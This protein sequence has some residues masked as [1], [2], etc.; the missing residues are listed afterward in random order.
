MDK[1]GW[2]SVKTKVPE[3]ETHIL[4]YAVGCGIKF[5]YRQEFTP[6]KNG[7]PLQFKVY[8]QNMVRKDVTHWMPLPE[9]PQS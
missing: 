8:G 6:R 3:V 5:A 2:I 9:P 7:N 1:N 4:I